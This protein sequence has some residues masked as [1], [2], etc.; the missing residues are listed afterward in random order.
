MSGLGGIA[1]TAKPV[2]P[3]QRQ[4]LY[5]QAHSFDTEMSRNR[6]AIRLGGYIVGA[7]GMLVG[8][9]GMVAAA[10]LFPLK[11][12]V[13]QFVPWN[14]EVGLVGDTVLAKDAPETLFRDQQAH[15]DLLK[16]VTAAETWVS[17]AS[18]INFHTV[19]VMSGRD[20]QA[21]FAER[22]SAKNPASPRILYGN[23]AT[24]RVEHFRFSLLGRAPGGAQVW[25]V[26]FD[27]TEIL[28]G[29]LGVAR[30]W[31]ATVTFAWHPA[32]FGSEADRAINL[33]GFQCTSYEAGAA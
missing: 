9:C 24:V 6:S 3:E 31:V 2:L 12:T 7:A 27:R 26:R 21:A 15:A 1:W 10:A 8:V 11:Q 17:D 30:P 14:T 13:V 25:Q 5:A 32:I 29:N 19:A 18:D 16:F 28:G 33:T 4:E 20:Q 23:K 22:M